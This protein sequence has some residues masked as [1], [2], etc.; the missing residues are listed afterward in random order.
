MA[1]LRTIIRRGVQVGSSDVNRAKAAM[2]S[3]REEHE[4]QMQ[5]ASHALIMSTA[6]KEPSD[7]TMVLCW[8]LTGW[9]KVEYSKV[10]SAKYTNWKY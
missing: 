9:V 5:S 8:C 2:Q 1:R 6:P 10:K 7:N 3:L 4:Q